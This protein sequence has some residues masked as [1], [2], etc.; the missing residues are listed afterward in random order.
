M[1]PEEFHRDMEELSKD[2]LISRLYDSMVSSDEQKKMIQELQQTISTLN[3]TIANLNETIRELRN[4]IYGRSSESAAGGK[5][6]SKAIP[7]QDGD[8]EGQDVPDEVH[9]SGYTRPRKGKATRDELYN[10]L[11]VREEVYSLPEDQRACPICGTPMDYMGRNFVR[12][13]LRITP[14]V[15]ER[16][17][18]FQDV[19]VC[20]SCK[21]GEGTTIVPAPTPIS[22]MPHSPASA[23]LVA[24]T[25]YQKYANMMPT[26]RQEQS[27]LQLGIPL[28]R[29]TQSN[30]MITCSEEYLLPVYEALHRQLVRRDILHADEVP[31]QVLHEKDRA[32]TLKSYLWIYMTGNDGLPGIVLYDYHPGRNGDYAKEFLEGFSGYL[33]CD[34]YSGYNKVPD[35]ILV[36]CLAHAR[37]KFFEAIPTE[38]RKGIKLLD[39]NSEEQ[40]PWS[41]CP[42][43][44]SKAKYLPAE[45][46]FAYCN[47][48]FFQEREIKDLAPVERKALRE[49]KQKL[50]WDAFWS[51]L[52]TLSPTGGSKL[53]K[54]VNYAKNH[55]ETLMN[56]MKDGRCEI[57]NN[58]AERRAK[59][60][61]QGRKNFLFHNSV[62]GVKA[63]TV[64]LSLIETAKANNLNIYQYLYT[65]LLYMPDY[66]NE[67]KGIEALMPWSEFIQSRCT[68]LTDVENMKALN[69]EELPI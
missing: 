66:K 65:L 36:C 43:E 25:M 34:G 32:A 9:V 5:T 63:S 14:A 18:I 67:P 21:E 17:K 53:E 22:L 55:R 33:H 16:V 50:V 64:I 51:W 7:V 2:Q 41:K 6:K 59:S 56:Y 19:Y 68:G 49:E 29:E 23:S 30:W 37:R 4:K 61:V 69:R 47:Y 35:V 40:I 44:E 39:V 12:E 60:Y 15:V 11:P 62:P 27:F 3:S 31:C 24:Y 45:T 58:R 57:S 38:R 1:P 26:Y 10:Q 52:E 20:P 42:D 46:G 28:P 13:E 8:P 48:L 54:A